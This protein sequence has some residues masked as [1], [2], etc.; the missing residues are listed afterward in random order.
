MVQERGY[1]LGSAT[2][3]RFMCFIIVSSTSFLLFSFFGSTSCFMCFV[4]HSLTSFLLFSFFGSGLCN[5]VLN[6]LST[7]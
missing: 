7:L 6:L 3:S 5:T 4:T 1:G 2:T